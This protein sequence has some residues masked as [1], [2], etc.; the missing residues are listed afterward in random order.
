MYSGESI[1]R[2]IVKKKRKIIYN[3]KNKNIESMKNQI[4]RGRA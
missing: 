2:C 4:K 1:N 3:N